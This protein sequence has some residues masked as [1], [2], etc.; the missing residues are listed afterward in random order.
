MKKIKAGMK[1]INHHWVIRH[2]VRNV[3]RGTCDCGAVRFFVNDFSKESIELIEYYN[4]R[5]GKEGQGH[6]VTAEAI[7][8]E[9]PG[10]EKKN[11]DPPPEVKQ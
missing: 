10:V 6:M 3:S 8:S 1:G 2:F 7:K 9:K 5:E 4:K 11:G